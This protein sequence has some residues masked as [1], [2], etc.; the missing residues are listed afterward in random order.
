MI[1]FK[2]AEVAQQRGIEKIQHLADRT[3]LN[4]NTVHW[5]WTSR[6]TRIDLRTLDTLCRVL[7]AQPGDLMEWV[8]DSAAQG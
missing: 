7:N 4:Y 8:D 6:A 2:I 5:L 1:R 3:A